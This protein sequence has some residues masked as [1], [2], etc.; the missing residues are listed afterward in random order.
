MYLLHT[1]KDANL[2]PDARRPTPY[3]QDIAKGR[4]QKAVVRQAHQPGRRE[5]IDG[6]WFQY[7]ARV[8]SRLGDCYRS[9]Q[10]S[11]LQLVL[12]RQDLAFDDDRRLQRGKQYLVAD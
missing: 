3:F 11:R 4:G 8:K 10:N 2:F 7:L 6:S 12:G 9:I 5:K 1:T